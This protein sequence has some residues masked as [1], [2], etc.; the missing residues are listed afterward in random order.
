MCL[1]E[2]DLT[3]FNCELEQYEK[4]AACGVTGDLQTANFFVT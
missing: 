1:M 3:I 2:R 4:F